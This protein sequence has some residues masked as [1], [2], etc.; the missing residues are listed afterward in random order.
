MAFPRPPGLAG[1]ALT[2]AGRTLLA[3]GAAGCVTAY[4]LAYPELA[5]LALAVWL[6]LAGALALLL[7][8]PAA[9]ATL[10]LDTNRVRRGMAASAVVTVHETRRGAVGVIL[11]KLG[12]GR[13]RGRRGFAVDLPV[14]TRLVTGY[15]RA[16]PAGQVT[17]MTIALP[18]AV[19]GVHTVGPA[20]ASLLDPFG[21]LRRRIGLT[22]T[23]TLIVHPEVHDTSPAPSR[24]RVGHADLDGGRAAGAGL[25]FVSVREYVQDDRRQV[26]WRLSAHAGRL[27]VRQGVLPPE[28]ATAV[29]L[30]TCAA[31]YP[32]GERDSAFEAAVDAAASLV[33]ASAAAGAS[34]HL[35]TTT[36]GA[37]DISR[38]RMDPTPAL[39][40]LAAV[41]PSEQDS[42]KRAL[43][44]VAQAARRPSAAVLITGTAREKASAELFGL[45]QRIET[46]V[47]MR[48]GAGMNTARHVGRTIELDGRDAAAAVLA[49]DRIVVHGAGAR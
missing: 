8:G 47:V 49:W 21:A 37:I 15:V 41:A 48:I 34:V 40:L 17:T 6:V 42:V 3:G 24:R 13:G 18:T 36:G 28:S 35:L 31:S 29:V 16:A 22:T 32:A 25:A 14:G 33:V 39:D 7:I 19:R 9:G 5:V 38:G 20:A 11:Q 10:S 4:V 26:H 27:M 43:H 45:S 1:F 30:D 46:V 44:T 23:E 2:W 12:R